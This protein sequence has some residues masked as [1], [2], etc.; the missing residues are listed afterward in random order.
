MDSSKT[1]GWE[2]TDL[3]TAKVGGAYLFKKPRSGAR[4]IPRFSDIADSND[5][6]D[7]DACYNSSASYAN[8]TCYQPN[9][10]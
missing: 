9:T 1:I 5:H 6:C 8:E 2:T 7:N 10:S 4:K 3:K